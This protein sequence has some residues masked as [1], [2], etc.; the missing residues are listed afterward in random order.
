MDSNAGVCSKLEIQIHVFC[1]TENNSF[2][3]NR[4]NSVVNFVVDQK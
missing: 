1:R 3:L 4:W 2:Q